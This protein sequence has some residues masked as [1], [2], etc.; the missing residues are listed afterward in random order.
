MAYPDYPEPRASAR[1]V[2]GKGVIR[3]GSYYHNPI[4]GV[5][6]LELVLTDECDL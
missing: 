1:A 6:F 5:E 2:P 3:M 4:D